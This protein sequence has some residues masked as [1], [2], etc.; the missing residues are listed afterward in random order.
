MSEGSARA[1][2][3]PVSARRPSATYSGLAGMRRRTRLTPSAVS[4]PDVSLMSSIRASFVFPRFGEL[5]LPISS[6]S[7]AQHRAPSRSAPPLTRLDRAYCHEPLADGAELGGEDRPAGSRVEPE[8]A[9]HPLCQLARD[10]E[11][12]S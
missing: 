3:R 6:R 5:N 7:R 1:C 2:A 9:A 11:T 10:G 4:N 12:E 8:R